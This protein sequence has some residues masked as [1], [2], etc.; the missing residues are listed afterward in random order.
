MDV[1]VYIIKQLQAFSKNP[2]S[3]NTV[4]MFFPISSYRNDTS[5]NVNIF[6]IKDQSNSQDFH[7]YDFQI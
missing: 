7:C 6:Y 2:T 4:Q 3:K 1:F 5:F